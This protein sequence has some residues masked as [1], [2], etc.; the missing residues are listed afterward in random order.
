MGKAEGKWTEAEL[1]VGND[2]GNEAEWRKTNLEGLKESTGWGGTGA[3]WERHRL[4]EEL[5]T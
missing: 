5:D 4:G 3:G 1:G 2:P